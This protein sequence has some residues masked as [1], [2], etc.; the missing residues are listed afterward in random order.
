MNDPK[1]TVRP[2]DDRASTQIATLAFTPDLRE[3]LGSAC[4]VSYGGSADC[5]SSA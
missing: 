3:A 2:N 1:I 4:C 5:G